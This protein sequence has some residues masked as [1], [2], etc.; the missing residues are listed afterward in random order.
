MKCGVRHLNR[1]SYKVI[2]S[3]L[4]CVLQH[5]LKQK[6]SFVSKRTPHDHFDK[7]RRDLICLPDISSCVACKKIDRVPF[8]CFFELELR[9]ND[10]CIVVAK[11]AKATFL[12]I[13][14]TKFLLR[15]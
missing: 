10:A 6:C 8:F 9:K 13:L 2:L 1:K 12:N 15:A 11:V 14:L 5:G 4:I 7:E 3:R